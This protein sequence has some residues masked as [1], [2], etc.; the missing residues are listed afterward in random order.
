[1]PARA[2]DIVLF[3]ATGF[4]GRLTAEYLARHAPND[5]RWALA[6]RN[7]GKLENVRAQLAAIDPALSTLRLL[8]GDSGDP[9]SLRAIAGDARVI[10]STVGPYIV[11]GEP[12]V[13]ACAEAGTDYLDLTGEP[14]FV[15]TM[16]VRYHDRAR[17]SGARLVHAC[18]FDSIPYDIGAYY[19]V[20][21]L[22]EDVPLTVH[23]YVE[24]SGR[25]SGGTAHSAIT[26][27]SRF[28]ALIAAARDRKRAEPAVTRRSVQAG[29][30]RPHHAA[31]TG[32]WALPMPTLDP[33]IVG[34]SARALDRYGPDF[35]YSHCAS[36]P[37]LWT[38][39]GLAVGVGG[40][41]ALA[42]LP[43]ARNALLKRMPQGNGPSPQQRAR[44]WFRVTFTGEGGGQRVVTRVSGG[45]PGY[46]ET[47]RMLGESALALAL[48]DLP[49]TSGQVTTAAAMGDALLARLQKSGMSFEVL[50]S[51]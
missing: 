30:G 40:L 31:A 29:A 28:P 20:L 13:A 6:G 49:E 46:D 37:H 23:G 44:S 34:R 9:A 11:H 18:G 50:E 15:D 41:V 12:L 25:P 36:V 26:A 48:D 22:P 35:R 39:A 16:Y 32:G 24:A 17:R 19:T 27:F 51:S 21:Q 14:E 43:P 2:Y 7:V 10:A 8:E 45:D 33:Q 4:A 38:A 5:C 42:Q 3:G 47:A 1:M